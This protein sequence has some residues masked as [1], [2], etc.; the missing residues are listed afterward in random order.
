MTQFT[1]R[2]ELHDAD[3][4][5]YETLHAEMESRGFSRT[6]QSNEGVWYHLPPAEYDFDGNQDRS[7]VLALAKAAAAVT[8][9]T[10]ALLVTQ[11]TG[12]TWLGLEKV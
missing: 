5:D 12:R 10:A 2:V 3:A 6:I 8:S 7:Q 1:T 11:T 4:D 9:K